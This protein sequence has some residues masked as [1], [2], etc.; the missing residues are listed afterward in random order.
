MCVICSNGLLISIPFFSI[1]TIL[2]PLSGACLSSLSIA[3]L[4]HSAR[5]GG[6]FPRASG[7]FVAAGLGRHSCPT[8]MLWAGDSQKNEGCIP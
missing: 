5:L 1:Q 2:F 3:R 7:A 4:P 8:H 6:D